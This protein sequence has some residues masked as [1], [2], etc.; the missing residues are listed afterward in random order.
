MPT[1][2]VPYE[3]GTLKA[4][5]RRNGKVELVREIQTAGA[6]AQIV[7]VPD[8]KSIKDD[9]TDLSFVT[10]KIVDKKGTVVPLADNEVKFEV[11]GPGFIAGVDNGSEISHESFKANHRKAFHGLAM[12]I[13][14]SKGQPGQIILKATSNGLT[15]ASVVIKAR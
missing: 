2:R 14:Q 4:I 11:S 9:G 8:R 10:V 7:L 12:A 6:A 13:I 3:E 15:P 1:W 5:S